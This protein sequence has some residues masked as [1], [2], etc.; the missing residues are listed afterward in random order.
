MKRF[1]G[2]VVLVAASVGLIWVLKGGPSS[3][4]RVGNWL[5]PLDGFYRTARHAMASASA[6]IDLPD[7]E[8]TVTVERDDRGV[9]HIFAAND[10]DAIVALGYVTAQDRLFE[11]DFIARVAAGRLSE[12]FGPGA[13]ESDRFLR[14]TGME[15]GARRNAERILR[16]G[17]IERDLM[18]WY[19]AGVNA[20]LDGLDDAD[21]PFEFRL[22]GY[23]PDRFSPLQMVRLLQYMTFDLTY[24]TDDADYA[25][26]KAGMSE[27]E[28]GKLYPRFSVLYKPIV[29][30]DE[31][32]RRRFGAVDTPVTEK[33]MPGLQTLAAMQEGQRRLSRSIAEGFLEGKGSNNWAVSGARSTTGSPI[34]AG[35]MHLSLTLPAIWYEVHLVTP[36]MNTYGVTIPGAA[37]P[38]EAFND[39]L[40]WAFTNTGADQ[41]DHYALRLDSTRTKYWF[42]GAFRPLEIVSD[43]IRVKGAVPVIDSLYYAHWGPV[44]MGND[45]AV[46]LRWVAHE[47]SHTMRALWGMNHADD[48]ASFERALRS[49]DTPMQN[50]LYAGVDGRIAIRSTG[51]LPIRR[52]GEGM[53]LLDG[54]SRRYEWT[55]RVPF[56]DLPHVI[57]PKR[58]YL[59][60]SN[61]QPAGSW[62]PYYLGYDWRA[63]YRSLRIDT[64]LNGKTKHSI[65]DLK[66]YQSDVHAVQRDLFVPLLDTLT[67]LSPRADSLRGTLSKWDGDTGVEQSEPLVLET[68]LGILGRLSWDEA[69]FEGHRKPAE[70]R[71]Y[72]LLTIEPASDWLDIGSTDEREDAAALLR[73]ALDSAS[74]ELSDTYGRDPTG[75]RW[76][77][78][79]KII[80]Q[81]ITKSEALRPLWRGPF[82]YPGYKATVSPGSSH[83]TTH[84]ASWRVVVDLSQTPPGGFGVYPGGASGNPFSPDYDGQIRDY[85]DFNHYELL[86]P[87]TRGSLGPRGR[88]TLVFTPDH[89]EAE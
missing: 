50:I 57:D 24:R 89:I 4:P 16:E 62:Y 31:R 36:T 87:N 59:S 63:Q 78:H 37:L 58:G 47:Q 1:L 21:L 2:L 68:F 11:M 44:T 70:I 28:F 66:R 38:V 8:A 72:R 17:G 54:S 81:H 6:K 7:L 88:S 75:W 61:Q 55:G 35:D 19:S 45:G 74:V 85:L 13:L 14:R 9:P 46:A 48:Y 83:Q 20:Y 25:A 53:G 29:P 23:R 10:R 76:G 69:V 80:F 34:L 32:P 15:W 5:D 86:K 64:L 43:T 65:D 84:S 39:H 3:V 18:I 49:W 41:I 60:S 67:G 71:L 82:E 33:E 51:Y 26:L 77:N 40:A 42:E 12:A 30:D 56:D 27:K 22:L 52:A 73:L 79:H